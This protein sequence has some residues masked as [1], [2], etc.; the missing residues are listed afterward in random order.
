[1]KIKFSDSKNDGRLPWFSYCYERIGVEMCYL[2]SLSHYFLSNYLDSVILLIPTGIAFL[3]LPIAIHGRSKKIFTEY[4][5]GILTYPVLWILAAVYY[6]GKIYNYHFKQA[7]SVRGWIAHQVL[8]L[9]TIAIP[10]FIELNPFLYVLYIYVLIPYHVLR[11]MILPIKWALHPMYFLTRIIEYSEKKKEPLKEMM[12]SFPLV[13]SFRRENFPKL[14][15]LWKSIKKVTVITNFLIIIFR[16]VFVAILLLS[17]EACLITSTMSAGD[18]GGIFHFKFANF[19]Q[20]MMGRFFAG[21]LPDKLPFAIYN[22]YILCSILFWYFLTGFLFIA[23]FLSF[24]ES[25]QHIQDFAQYYVDVY[26]EVH[27][28]RKVIAE[29]DFWN[30][31]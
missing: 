29:K 27:A 18:K 10:L 6:L 22:L 9:I 5:L 19:F 2:T 7:E 16:S 21:D 1:M 3:A 15:K 30:K 8:F 28:E 11:C 25:M 13:F 23:T 24:D 17:L 12:L 31:M 14:K 26:D 4:Y 20:S